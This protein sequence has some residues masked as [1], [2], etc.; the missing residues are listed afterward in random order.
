MPLTEINSPFGDCLI[1]WND[2][3]LSRFWLPPYESDG[4]TPSLVEAENAPDWVQAVVR[5]VQ[6]H[7]AGD[8]Q[9]FADVPVAW[10]IV[11]EFQ[12]AVYRH[13]L[14]ITAGR[15]ATYGAISKSRGLGP[16][17]SRAVGTALGTNPWPLIVPCHRVI[18]ANG[19]MTGF[20]SPG[21]IRTK[22]RLLALEG[23]ELML[24]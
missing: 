14:A 5:R 8:L 1:E 2:R 15:T 23:A 10:P 24:E 21:G 13:T 16:E 7:L 22:T 19:K 3:A 4:L 9:D 12:R 20:S 18:A 6:R 17:G 11:S